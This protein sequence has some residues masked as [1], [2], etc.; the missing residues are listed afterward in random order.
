MMCAGAESRGH[1][2]EIPLIRFFP[3][4]ERPAEAVGTV[5]MNRSSKQNHTP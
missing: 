3:R 4:G 2:L 1:F 5:P